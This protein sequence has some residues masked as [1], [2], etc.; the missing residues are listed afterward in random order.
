MLHEVV[1]RTPSDAIME[2]S[3]SEHLRYTITQVQF[4]ATEAP[5]RCQ[6]ALDCLVRHRQGLLWSM[7]YPF[8]VWAPQITCHS[9]EY[10]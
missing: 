10:I 2:A 4:L 8:G 5:S 9:A 6:R 1:D 7:V 3:M